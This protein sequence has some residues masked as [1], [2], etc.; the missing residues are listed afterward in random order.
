MLGHKALVVDDDAGIRLMLQRVLAR[1]QFDVEVALAG[2]EALEKLLAADYDVIVLDLMMPRITG[3]GVV[4]YLTRT[5][6]DYIPRIVAVTAFGSRA[7]AEIA[8]PVGRVIEKPF[9]LNHLL[10]E[11]TECAWMAGP[12]H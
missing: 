11:V 6:P 10:R 12:H 8:P 1:N 4:E 5:R 9:D 2:A 7:L 3:Q